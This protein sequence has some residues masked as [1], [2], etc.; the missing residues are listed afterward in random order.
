L[1]VPKIAGLPIPFVSHN[2]VDTSRQIEDA[3]IFGDAQR[4]VFEQRSVEKRDAR[5]VHSLIAYRDG[6]VR[7]CQ[8]NQK[9]NEIAN[10]CVGE[11]VLSAFRKKRPN[12]FDKRVYGK[13][14]SMLLSHPSLKAAGLSF[15]PVTHSGSRQ[16][17][18]D[19]SNAIRDI[20]DSLLRQGVVGQDGR[21]RPLMLDDVLVT[22]R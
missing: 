6:F 9:R 2:G 20:F 10:V 13:V 16:R 14:R 3:F 12:V 15:V 1:D 5:V 17:S 22:C 19:E 8:R 21:Q 11:I 18:P 7:I 4:L